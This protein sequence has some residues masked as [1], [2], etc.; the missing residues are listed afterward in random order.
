MASQ[1]PVNELRDWAIENY[2]GSLVSVNIEDLRFISKQA[3][4]A[5]DNTF[6]HKNKKLRFVYLHAARLLVL[7][8]SR[9]LVEKLA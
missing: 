7:D 6:D 5:A 2:N 8:E 1:I 3:D 9:P 4:A